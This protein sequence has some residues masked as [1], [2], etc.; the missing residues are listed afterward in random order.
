MFWRLGSAELSRPV[1]VTVFWKQVWMRPSSPITL[2][3]PST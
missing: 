2:P 1:A 3:R